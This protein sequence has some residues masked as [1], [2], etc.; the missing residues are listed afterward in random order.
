MEPSSSVRHGQHTH[1]FS[2]FFSR[3]FSCF[4][5]LKNNE[6]H[7]QRGLCLTDRLYLRE[8]NKRLARLCTDLVVGLYSRRTTNGER[9]FSPRAV[10]QMLVSYDEESK[11]IVEESLSQVIQHE[12]KQEIFELKKIMVELCSRVRNQLAQRRR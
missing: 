2:N 1:C 10:E 11:K 3:I 6:P 8:L 5:S 9:V 12:E 4:C 7:R